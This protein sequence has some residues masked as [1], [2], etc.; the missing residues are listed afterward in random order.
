MGKITFMAL[1]QCLVMNEDQVASL[2]F[3]RSEVS[4]FELCIFCRGISLGH[5]W[6]CE[7]FYLWDDSATVWHL[8]WNWQCHDRKIT[9]P[10]S[11]MITH[12]FLS[13]L[14][15]PRSDKP[16]CYGLLW[17]QIFH[18]YTTWNVFTHGLSSIS[19]KLQSSSKRCLTSIAPVDRLSTETIGN[20]YCTIVQWGLKHQVGIFTGSWLVLCTP[21]I[22]SWPACL[23]DS[24]ILSCELEKRGKYDSHL[25]EQLIRNF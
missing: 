24:S 9:K 8:W 3:E 12:Q 11:E 17:P 5:M 18:I 19:R 20:V 13:A 14:L 15:L 2:T 7:Q 25:W 21:M 6:V 23:W 22:H 1:W 10:N 16:I 4:L